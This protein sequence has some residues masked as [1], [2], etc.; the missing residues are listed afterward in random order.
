MFPDPDGQYGTPDYHVPK[1]PGTPQQRRSY[2]L[3]W[4]QVLLLVIIC[5]FIF[6]AVRYS[7]TQAQPMPTVTA[8]PEV[9][10]SVWQAAEDA[11]I[12]TLNRTEELESCIQD[13]LPL[14]VLFEAGISPEEIWESFV[15]GWSDYATQVSQTSATQISQSRATQTAI[16][17]YPLRATETRQ[18]LEAEGSSWSATQVSQIRLRLTEASQN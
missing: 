13:L 3:N 8:T 4:L 9:S 17:Q 6:I 1:P 12:D 14:F 10:S 5:A 16:S 18:S 11:C 2:R 15:S 7:E